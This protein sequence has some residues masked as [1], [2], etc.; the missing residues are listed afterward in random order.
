MALP[1]A[2]D[3]LIPSFSATTIIGVLLIALAIFG[4]PVFRFIGKILSAITRGKV[5]D[6]FI[7]SFLV[8]VGL[9]LIWGVSIAQ[10]L[11]QS[12]EFLLILA[13][14]IFLVAIFIFAFNTKEND[15]VFK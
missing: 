1:T 14:V 5:K 3:L 11:L 6:G 9:I 10:T 8:V 15:G 2:L 12:K 7:V 4:G 13:G